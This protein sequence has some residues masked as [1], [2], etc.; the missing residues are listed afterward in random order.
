MALS[1]QIA[2]RMTVGDRQHVD[3]LVDAKRLEV[4]LRYRG[5]QPCRRKIAGGKYVIICTGTITDKRRQV[6]ADSET[7]LSA[8]ERYLLKKLSKGASIIGEVQR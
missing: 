7:G 8:S 6:K 5:K 2:E 3:S 4:A 1:A